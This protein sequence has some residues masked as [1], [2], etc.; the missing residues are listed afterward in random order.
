MSRRA[1]RCAALRWSSS[2]STRGLAVEA[3]PASSHRA[4]R[5]AAASACA[6]PA[7]A[8]WS[9]LARP[10][11]T[12]P[13]VGVTPWRTSRTIVGGGGLGRAVGMRDVNLLLTG[14]LSSG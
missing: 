6:R 3:V 11:S 12:W 8:R 1:R 2:S 4:M 10:G 7:S 9:P 5:A 13:V 14:L